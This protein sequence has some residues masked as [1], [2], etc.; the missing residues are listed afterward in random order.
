M[1]QSESFV[2]ACSK[3]SANRVCC[4][5]K[6]KGQASAVKF[7]RAG[8]ARKAGSNYDNHEYIL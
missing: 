5:D 8:E 7:G 4:I 6:Q 1:I 3:A 2:S